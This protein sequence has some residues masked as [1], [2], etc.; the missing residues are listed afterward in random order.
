MFIPYKDK[1]K[2][3]TSLQTQFKIKDDR[4]LNKYME[5]YLDHRPD[6]SIRL[7]P[8]YL[9]QRIINTIPGMDKYSDKPTTSVITTLVNNEGDKANKKDFNYTYVIVS[10]NFLTNSSRPKAQF[11]VYQ[12]ARFSANTKLPHNQALK[13]VAK[14]LKDTSYKGIIMNPYPKNGI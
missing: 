1:T 12:C 9:T 11:V 13:Y 10:L 5:M 2:K 7:N 8:P 4:E 14:Y 6:R 3:G